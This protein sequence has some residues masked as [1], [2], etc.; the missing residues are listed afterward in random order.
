MDGIDGGNG[1]RLDLGGDGP[2]GGIN[3]PVG[4]AICCFFG[5]IKL[6]SNNGG[7]N[8]IDGAETV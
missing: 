1:G 7:T 8:L 2:R 6:G 4:I 5:T 3:G